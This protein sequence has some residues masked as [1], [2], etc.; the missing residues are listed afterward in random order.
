[1]ATFLSLCEDVARESGTVPASGTESVFSTVL[2]VTGRKKRVTYWVRRAWDDIQT[3]QYWWTWLIT[4]FTA[5]VPAGAQTHTA[6]ALGIN[7]RFGRWI[8]KLSDNTSA[9]TI[10]KTA[11]GQ[12][13][14]TLLT[15][16]ERQ[17]F[18]RH[19][20]RGGAATETGYPTHFTVDESQRLV[21]W[22]IPDAHYTVAGIYYKAP[23]DL[24][25]DDDT[26]ECPARYHKL[27]ELRALL[28][29]MRYDEAPEMYVLWREEAG[30]VESDLIAEMLP[31]VRRGEALA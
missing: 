9:F 23:Q 5:A 20:Q 10:W 11:D 31:P 1:M 21:F 22:P 30:R 14:E 8:W 13:T 18:R 2:G 26:P 15:Y 4:P 25:G 7:A 17:V 19:F 3:S 28:R 24:T 6:A 29:L 16:V 12:A 27:I